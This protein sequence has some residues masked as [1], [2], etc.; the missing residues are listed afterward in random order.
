MKPLVKG[1]RDYAM[2]YHH[3]LQEYD[4]NPYFFH[5]DLTVKI[6]DECFEILNGT[7]LA[8]AY[9]IQLL[10]LYPLLQSCGYLHDMLEDSYKNYRDIAD[11]FGELIADIVYACQ[12]EK[13]KTRKER[14]S[15]KFY[16]ELRNVIYAPFIKLC[17][18]FA[19][20]KYSKETGSTMFNKYMSEL[21]EFTENTTL[22]IA[23]MQPIEK[24]LT[25]IILKRFR[26][27]FHV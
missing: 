3:P 24:A 27:E 6:I 18:R 7:E 25:E 2:T 19:N 21:P 20:M 23:A 9:Q 4:G 13:G 1:A 12:C 11:C 26:E 15:P 22:H 14:F 16:S 8:Q 5:L 10:S 17:D